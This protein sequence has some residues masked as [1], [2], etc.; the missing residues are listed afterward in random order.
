[1]REGNKDTKKVKKKRKVSFSPSPM[2]DNALLQIKLYQTIQLALPPPPQPPQL[3]ALSVTTRK[4][5]S[6]AR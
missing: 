1:M 5:S 3:Q 2:M 4:C 6:L